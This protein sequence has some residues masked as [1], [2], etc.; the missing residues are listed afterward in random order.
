MRGRD[1]SKP[2]DCGPMI[3]QTLSHYRILEKF[4]GDAGSP[5]WRN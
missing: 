5:A 4:G 1:E 2:E 3:W